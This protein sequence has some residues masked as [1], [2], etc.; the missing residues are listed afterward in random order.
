VVTGAGNPEETY[1]IL[2]GSSYSGTRHVTG[3]SNGKG[4]AGDVIK[5][6]PHS[7]QISTQ[8]PVTPRRQPAASASGKRN[9]N[10]YQ[11]NYLWSMCPAAPEAKTANPHV[12]AL[13]TPRR[14]PP[15]K[16]PSTRGRREICT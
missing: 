15:A 1:H 6:T 14:I 10:R 9:T 11:T 5:R 12:S 7:G 8:L 16:F 13:L 2:S 4:G 3:P